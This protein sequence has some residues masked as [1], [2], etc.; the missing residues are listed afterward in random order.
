[1]I[2]GIPPRNGQASA[3]SSDVNLGV[4]DSVVREGSRSGSKSCTIMG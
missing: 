2:R 4:L 3:C 1:M